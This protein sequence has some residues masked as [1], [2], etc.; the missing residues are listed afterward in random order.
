[1]IYR[2]QFDIAVMRVKDLCMQNGVNHKHLWV[3]NTGKNYAKENA[4]SFSSSTF[5]KYLRLQKAYAPSTF[6]QFGICTAIR[7]PFQ[8]QNRVPV[9]TGVSVV[10][11]SH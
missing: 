1:M 3:W 2:R 6:Y 11:L 5:N 7:K 4:R 10:D 8:A 9:L